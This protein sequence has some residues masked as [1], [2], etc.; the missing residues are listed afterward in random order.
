M[1][2]GYAPGRGVTVQLVRESVGKK[3]EEMAWRICFGSHLL[4]PKE[5]YGGERK[6]RELIVS[7]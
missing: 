3:P 4:P 7:C 1:G 2:G 6:Q 5:V